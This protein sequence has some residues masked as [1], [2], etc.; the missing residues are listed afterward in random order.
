MKFA[1]TAINKEGTRY[2]DTI[3]AADKS[4]FYQEFRKKGDV[5]VSVEEKAAKKSFEINILPKRIKQM[6][7]IVFAR[8]IGNMLEAGLSL[9]RAINVMERQVTNKKLKETCTALNNS[10]SSLSLIHI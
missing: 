8:N 9:S 4:V 6:D 5:L 7:K 10:I 2:S 3:E 1:Y